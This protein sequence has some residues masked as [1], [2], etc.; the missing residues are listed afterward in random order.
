MVF[1]QKHQTI[2]HI[3][4]RFTLLIANVVCQSF[5][6]RAQLC[7]LAFLLNTSLLSEITNLLGSSAQHP[8]QRQWS[9]CVWRLRF[10]STSVRHCCLRVSCERAG[11]TR[12]WYR[13]GT[14]G[15]KTRAAG[16]LIASQMPQAIKQTCTP[17]PPRHSNSIALST[18]PLNVS[19]P[20]QGWKIPHTS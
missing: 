2:Y 7:F 4:R 8:S 13:P 16:P 20:F 5:H 10:V 1:Q 9:Y 3:E 11:V 14:A 18:P 17:A 15:R 6:F 19:T 12:L